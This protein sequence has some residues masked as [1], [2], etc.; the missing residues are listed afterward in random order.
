M[1]IHH[2]I[3]DF[4][5]ARARLGRTAFVPTMGNLHE[6]HIALMRQ[7]AD[8]ADAVTAS[9]F[10]N[11]LQF[12]PSD[13]FDRYPRTLA[14]DAEKLEQ[15]GVTDLFAPDEAEMYPAPQTYTVEPYIQHVNILDGEFRPG[16]FGGVTTV[17]MKLLNIARPEVAVFGKKDYQQLMVLSN[18]V[19]QFAMPVRILAG[20]TVRA[21]DGLALSSRNGYLSDHERAK[22]PMLYRL[23]GNIRDS[24]AGGQHDFDTLQAKAM[25]EL[26]TSGWQPDYVEIRRRSDLQKPE[27]SDEKLVVLAAAKIGST[28]LIDNLEI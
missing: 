22:A 18:M 12:G 19:D 7:A 23:L 24:V 14:D 17:V 11:R 4:R 9:V 1:R 25:D 13:D 28:R 2:T 6:G 26:T 16:H 5:A 20:E 3:A 8:A 15:A 10:V 27:A 21:S